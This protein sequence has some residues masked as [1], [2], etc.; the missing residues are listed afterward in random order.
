MKKLILIFVV[1]TIL[2][3]FFVQHLNSSES[4]SWKKISAGISHATIEVKS[5]WSFRVQ[6]F[7]VELDMLEIF[8]IDARKKE[9]QNKVLTAEQMAHTSDAILAINGSYFDEKHRPL[10]LVISEG[11]RIN[12]FRSA[13]WG[14]L[15]IKKNNAYLIHT[16]DWKK[17]PVNDVSFAIQT[18]PRIVVNSKPVKLKNQV[19]RRSIIGIWPGRK[20]LLF[21]ITDI[22]KAEA[23]TIA[24]IMARKESE[25]GLGCIE[26]VMLDGGPSA[27]LYYKNGNLNYNI[28]GGWPV[29]IGVGV[30]KK[31]TLSL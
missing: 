30:R 15:Y 21:A 24:E 4:I 8:A 7:K 16:N 23:N 5:D 31:S 9:K 20:T 28:T 18:G 27:Q 2:I 10:G 1:L 26:A 13:D 19:A 25:G 12:S 11:K 17:N 22:G 6:L 29:P 14:V 3:M